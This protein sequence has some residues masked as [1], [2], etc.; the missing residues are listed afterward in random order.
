MS[1]ART[2]RLRPAPMA[3][4]TPS[5]RSP[6]AARTS[7]RLA[8][9]TV[10]ARR[11]RRTA[12]EAART[13]GRISPTMYSATGTADADQPRADVGYSSAIRSV[14][15]ATS[16][17]TAGTL[18]PE[19]RRATTRS[20]RTPRFVGLAGRSGS[21]ST[22]S[23]SEPKISRWG[24]RTPTTSR[25]TPSTG[26]VRPTTSSAPPKRRC[27]RSWE[28]I[29]VV[30]VA[31]GRSSRGARARPRNGRMPRS[32]RRLPLTCTAASSSGRSGSSRVRLTH[33]QAPSSST[34]VSSARQSW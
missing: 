16:C 22:R 9:L 18:P 24:G 12:T 30:A 34:V 13:L 19:G 3:A 15:A 25:P 29:T 32:S 27:H 8:T 10:A 23:G 17:S 2:R 7:M 6:S 28:I 5:S 1:R 21:G 20:V 14:R 26:R 33:S 11:R 4:R 31:P